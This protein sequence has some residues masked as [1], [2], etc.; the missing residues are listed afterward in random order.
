MIHPL[1]MLANDVQT[2][3]R[4]QVMDIRHS[5]SHRILDRD[6]RQRRPALVYR[7][8]RILERMT[9]HGLHLR[10][11]GTTGQVRVGPGLT[12]EGDC[13][14]WICHGSSLISLAGGPESP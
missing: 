7:R 10:P 12:L 5:S 13:P 6:H 1:V 9:R 14:I 4:E 8:K 11:R 2:G 3:L